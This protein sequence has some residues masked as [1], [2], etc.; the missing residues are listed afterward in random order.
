MGDESHLLSYFILHP[1]AEKDLLFQ[2]LDLGYPSFC[3]KLRII[4]V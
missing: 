3:E 4:H 1:D 2:A